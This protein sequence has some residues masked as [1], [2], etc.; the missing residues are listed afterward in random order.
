M[1]IFKKGDV[2]NVMMVI[3][4]IGELRIEAIKS[5][6]RHL[7]PNI[8]FSIHKIKD[9]GDGHLASTQKDVKKIRVE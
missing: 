5:I 9:S 7:I 3:N 2:V 8:I 1:S 6:D 4:K